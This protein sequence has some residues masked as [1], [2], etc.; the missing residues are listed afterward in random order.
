LTRSTRPSRSILR[1]ASRR[2]AVASPRGRDAAPLLVALGDLML[3]VVV[4]PTRAIERGTDVPGTVTFRRGGSAANVC[5]AFVRTGGR[6]RLV[7]SVGTDP[8]VRRLV[9]AVRAE[10]V[11]AAVVRR[12]GPSGR[13]AVLIEK[14]GERSFV[15]QRGTADAMRPSD[16]R[17]GWFAGAS[18][19][20]VPAYSL[21]TRPVADAA[22][23]AVT[24][25]RS[26]GA[27]VSVDLS[28]R[29][30][31]L[32]HGAAAASTRVEAIGAGVLFANRDE[33]T[34]LLGRSRPASLP[35]LLDLAPLVIVKDGRA[36]AHVLW[37]D[38]PDGG[39]GRLIVAAERLRVTDSTG[40][41]DAFAAGFLWVL[42]DAP[43]VAHRAAGAGGAA[44]SAPAD[45]SEPA[46]S[47]RAFDATRLRRAALAGHR[48]AGR[49]L[50]H[51]APDLELG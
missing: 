19:L 33:A 9:A 42:A 49:G 26:A 15:T 30:P 16:L 36:G 7:T 46:R 17:T 34:A 11:D 44:P 24:L 23:H 12:P 39:T 40:A 18:V 2:V 38:G 6:A 41:G 37:R 29:G 10:G 45:R 35:R 47:Q 1:P 27:L 13:L 3:D 32:E 51:R 20:H 48:A 14:D 4:V 31:L 21:L 50:A 22:A 5:A 8:W 43:R 25:A 28:S